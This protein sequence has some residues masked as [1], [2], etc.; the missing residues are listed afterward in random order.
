MPMPV[1]HAT[2]ILAVR[3]DGK[4]A[5]GGDGQVS[6]GDTVMKAN[7]VKVRLL[8]GGAVVA[9]FAGAVADALTLFE[10]FEEK[11]E[12]FPDNLPRAAV[13]LT[14]EWRSDRVLRRL[15]AQLVIADN[16]NGFVLSGS[17]EV[18]EPE[19][20]VLA[21]GAGG[22]YAQAAA[23]ALLRETTLTSREIVTK[24][25]TIAGEICIYTNTNLTVLE[26]ER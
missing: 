18:I 10:K 9:G 25:L 23:R 19:D 12:R 5:I 11:L 4:V 3:R 15:E 6:V 13:E 17:G 1:I 16:R 20:G 21:I 2:T 7:A 26:P 8:K 22:P 14:K 24:A